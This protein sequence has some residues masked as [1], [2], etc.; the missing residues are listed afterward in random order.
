MV[1]FIV[2]GISSVIFFFY[3]LI[4]FMSF[5]IKKR[6]KD[7]IGRAFIYIIIAILFLVIRRL[8][9]IFIQAEIVASI[10]YFTDGITLVFAILFFMAVFSFYR[11]IKKIGSKRSYNGLDNYKKR[12][13]RI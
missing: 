10:P 9:Q 1:D 6:L 12:L 11:A 2:V 8:Q 3:L 5:S 13:G 7:D 4:I